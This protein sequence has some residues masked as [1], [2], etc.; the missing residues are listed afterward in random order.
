MSNMLKRISLIN[1]TSITATGKK[2]ILR[3]KKKVKF[4]RKRIISWTKLILWKI[5]CILYLIMQNLHIIFSF[6]NKDRLN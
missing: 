6:R 5:Y 3:F 2:T 1:S 4:Q